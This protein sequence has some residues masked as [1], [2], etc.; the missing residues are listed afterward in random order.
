MT[1]PL[2]HLRVV[3]LCDGLAGAYG[4]LQFAAWGAA[5]TVVEPPE[6]SSLRRLRPTVVDDA[7]KRRSLVWEYVAA[8]KRSA[9]AGE[10]D[11]DFTERVNGLLEAADVLVTDWTPERLDASGL[12]HEAL[13]ARIP[14]LVQVSARPFGLSGPNAA[15]AATDLTV[16]AA[17][18]FMSMNGLPGRPPLRA[19]ANVVPY[20]CGV[21][22]FVGA[23]AAL[24]ERKRSGRGQLVEAA[25]METIATFVNHLRTAYSGKPLERL[26]SAVGGSW[27]MLRCGDDRYI[28]IAPVNQL[29]N[30]CAALGID[31]SEVPKALSQP[32]TATADAAQA[33][34]EGHLA[35]RRAWDVW[36]TLCTMGVPAGL[37]QSPND[38]LDDPHLAD[39]DFLRRVAVPGLGELSFPGP[40]ARLSK[41][42]MPLTRPAPEL[43]ATESIQEAVD[44]DLTTGE[45]PSSPLGDVRIIDLTGAWIGPYAT[46][47]LSM[48]GANVIKIEGPRRPDVWRGWRAAVVR[49]PVLGSDPEAHPGNLNPNFNSVNMNKRDLTLD[50]TSERG[51]ELLLRLVRDADILMENYTPRVME[52]FGLSYEALSAANPG[53]IRVSF[54]GFGQSGP[55]RDFKTN[56]G[57]TEGNCGWDMLLGYPHEGPLQMGGM[58]A[59]AI[60]GLHM[61]AAALIA[62]LH[63]T[64]TGTGQA[65]DGSMFEAGVGYVGEELLLASIEGERAER[66]GNRD[67]NMAPHG[68]FP[69]AGDDAWVAIA[70]QDDRAFARLAAVVGGALLDPRFARLAQRHEA[71]DELEA[72]LAEWTATRASRSVADELQAAGVA[73]APFL[74]TDAVPDDPQFAARGWFQLLS[75]PDVGERRHQG[76]PWRFSRGKTVV[77]TPSP[78]LGRD[79]EEVLRAELGLTAEAI[80]ALVV[81]GV[82]SREIE[83]RADLEIADGE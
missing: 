71:V 34:L 45:R 64:R 27:R 37:V 25:Q 16:Q 22:A 31:P 55:Y 39:R 59:D 67:P 36:N 17:S 46:L 19:P 41:S 5:V 18:G 7:G 83:T 72:R 77:R 42:P 65:I 47:L 79:S 70:A 30:L 15:H 74:K 76:P 44:D 14:R 24:W 23:L 4:A 40:P 62:L 9:V 56:G 61:A 81:A 33:F 51:R 35:D 75:H 60:I 13:E 10:G 3:E 52:N 58:P 73:A 20:A 57:A 2:E 11:A 53:V 82:T 8:G 21:S 43:G 26:G 50:L 28:S 78:R 29:Q 49:D 68:V 63:R 69:C 66:R 12:A 48:L 38:L 80:D 32:E 6:G 1:A 54:S